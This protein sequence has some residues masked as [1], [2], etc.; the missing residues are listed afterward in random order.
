[1]ERLGN[2]EKSVEHDSIEVHSRIAVV[3]GMNI[4]ENNDLSKLDVIYDMNLQFNTVDHYLSINIC[5]IILRQNKTHIEP[6]M[7]FVHTSISL[8]Y[9]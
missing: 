8:S 1:M 6:F 3:E 9:I 7:M 2:L 4:S 5:T